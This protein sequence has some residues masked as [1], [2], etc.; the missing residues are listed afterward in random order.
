MRIGI[1]E[2]F[3]SIDSGEKFILQQ[4]EALGD[5]A[6]VTT[7]IQAEDYNKT[8]T[9]RR[10]RYGNTPIGVYARYLEY[11]T[12]KMRARPFMKTS[13]D[14]NV[15]TLTRQT[16]LGLKAIYRQGT[17]LDGLLTR[18]AKRNRTAMRK[19]IETW[20]SPAT[21]PAT[22][23]RKVKRGLHSENLMETRSMYRAIK[24]KT[25]KYGGGLNKDLKALIDASEAII[26]RKARRVRG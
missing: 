20:S 5:G 1:E 14:S 11:G 26:K 25:K 16:G 2:S 4:L 17:T 8:R 22:V 6:E 9:Y 7:G 10:K 15:N 3:T 13:L 24:S 19:T 18:Q 12:S 21:S 23:K